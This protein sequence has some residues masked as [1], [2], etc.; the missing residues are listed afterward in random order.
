MRGTRVR[1]DRARAEFVGPDPAPRQIAHALR[2]TA[3][4]AYRAAATLNVP[5]GRDHGG[6]SDERQHECEDDP[7][8]QSADRRTTSAVTLG[9]AHGWRCAAAPPSAMRS[10]DR[11]LADSD[12]S[13]PT[14]RPAAHAKAHD[15]HAKLAVIW[16]NPLHAVASAERAWARPTRDRAAFVGAGLPL[17]RRCAR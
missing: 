17:Y 1:Q 10:A 15:E 7:A 9:L 3:S 14:T 16:L 2:M 6:H 5:T 12:G 13:E 8:N 4:H 11:G